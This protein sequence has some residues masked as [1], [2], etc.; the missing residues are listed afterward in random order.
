MI[1]SNHSSRAADGAGGE[2]PFLRSAKDGYA[3]WYHQT[4][5]MARALVFVG[6]AGSVL[7][8]VGVDR[9]LGYNMPYYTVLRSQ[10]RPCVWIRRCCPPCDADDLVWIQFGE[11]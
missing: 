1:N 11:Y 6:V 2:T 10:G 8:L 4:P 7:S 5:A 9:V 3:K